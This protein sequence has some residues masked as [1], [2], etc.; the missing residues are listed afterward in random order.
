MKNIHELRKS[1]EI[2]SK[3]PEGNKY[4]TINTIEIIGDIVYI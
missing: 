4:L 3:E 2:L 1:D